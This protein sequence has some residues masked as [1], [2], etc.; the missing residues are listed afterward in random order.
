MH[1]HFSIDHETGVTAV[2]YNRY[3]LDAIKNKIFDNLS[4]IEN[5]LGLSIKSNYVLTDLQY[6]LKGK[7]EMLVT[8]NPQIKID[9]NQR[10]SVVFECSQFPFILSSAANLTIGFDVYFNI[11]YVQFKSITNNSHNSYSIDLIFDKNLEMESME[12][13]ALDKINKV[14]FTNKRKS[15][16]LSSL[17][18]E[19]LLFQLYMT[20]DEEVKELLPEYY[21]PSAYDFKSDDFLSR[22]EVF[23]MLT[24]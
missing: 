21:A 17:K 2:G 16:R 11:T 22:L 15:N 20:K 5:S 18:D 14:S 1:N 4:R 6:I 19:I 10:T 24:L 12:F 8:G 7:T 3:I 9:K 23:S 13:K